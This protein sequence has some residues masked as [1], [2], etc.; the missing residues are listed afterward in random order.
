MPYAIIALDIDALGVDT[1]KMD[2][3]TCILIVDDEVDLCRLLEEYLTGEGYQVSVAHNG[4]EMRR[5][6]ERLTIDVVLLDLGLR[7][8]DGLALARELRT[9]IPGIGI[10]ILTGRGETID[11]IVGI[12]MG[13]DDYLVKPFH[14]RELLARIRS[15][16][17][18]A[19]VSGSDRAMTGR[20]LRFAGWVFNTATRELVSP[21]GEDVRLTAGEYVLLV[22][23]TGNPNRVLSRSQLLDLVGNGAAEGGAF[24]RTID[25]RIGRLR[26]KL[27]DDPK[28]PRLITTIRGG[29]Y[30]LAAPVERLPDNGRNG[31]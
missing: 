5:V 24:D 15:V 10:I 19:P 14:L 8:E 23:F 30:L 22:A 17:R 28:R 16:G 7:N 21:A 9:A 4:A 26:R 25:V 11:R 20:R 2:N 27:G 13:A 3:P 6:I 31:T 12:E 18:R 29:G 1:C